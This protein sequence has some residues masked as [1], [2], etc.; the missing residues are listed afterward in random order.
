MRHG[1]QPGIAN[2]AARMFKSNLEEHVWIIILP[3]HCLNFSGVLSSE[4]IYENF[5]MNMQ[6]ILSNSKNSQIL[7][8]KIVHAILSSLVLH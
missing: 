4:L 8:L 3:H 5:L 6:Y 1:G 7:L 2:S